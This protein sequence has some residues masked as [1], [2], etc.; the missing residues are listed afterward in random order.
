MYQLRRAY[1]TI[2]VL[3][4]TAMVNFIRWP[5]HPTGPTIDRTLPASASEVPLETSPQPRCRSNPFLAT[6][7]GSHQGAPV[8]LSQMPTELQMGPAAR[9]AGTFRWHIWP[10]EHYLL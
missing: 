3:K 9:C 4:G 1:R 7:P 5:P 6:C 8:K 2:T 10:P